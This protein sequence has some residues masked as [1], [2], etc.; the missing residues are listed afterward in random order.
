MTTLAPAHVH[1]HPPAPTETQ[2][3]LARWEDDGGPLYDPA[4]R[5][6]AV[7]WLRISA[8]LTERLP[9]LAGRQDI[10]VT[11]APGTLSGAP[12]AFFPATANLEIDAALF[13]PHRPRTLHPQ[14]A[15]DEERYPVAWGAM[16]HE[17]AHAAHSR[18]LTP[19]CP[20]AP[21]SGRRPKCWRSP[22]PRPPTSRAAPTTDASC[23]PRCTR[24]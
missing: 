9:E 1:H 13:T 18:W 7:E 2:E 19:P 22:A 11:C 17:A 10:L 12:A 20:A 6:E 23:G 4:P 15:G 5:P 8:E 21:L 16:I 3:A 14:R 24:W